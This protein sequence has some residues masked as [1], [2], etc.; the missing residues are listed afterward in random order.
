MGWNTPERKEMSLGEIVLLIVGFVEFVI[1]LI[2]CSKGTSDYESEST[3]ISTINYDFEKESLKR[4][5]YSLR[6][7]VNDLQN[8]VYTFRRYGDR[9][10]LDA[11]RETVKTPVEVN[12]EN[13]IKVESNEQK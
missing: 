11:L 8:E 5:N 12:I 9:Y 2:V 1:I 3:M 6:S 10:L 13:I 7:R 4:E